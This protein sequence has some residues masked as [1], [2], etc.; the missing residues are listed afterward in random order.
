[1]L[2]SDGRFVLAGFFMGPILRRTLPMRES[3]FNVA[4]YRFFSTSRWVRRS[5]EAQKKNG[6][7]LN[8]TTSYEWTDHHR[9]CRRPLLH[10]VLPGP[11]RHQLQQPG[12]D[13]EPDRQD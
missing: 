8:L 3:F 1:M 12:P 11:L 2:G 6:F 4:H 9:D 10:R 5:V 7:L 13:G